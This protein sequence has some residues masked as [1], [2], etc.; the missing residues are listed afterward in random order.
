MNKDLEEI[1]TFYAT[2]P[3]DE[4]AKLLINKSKDNPIASL[5]DSL[6]SYINHKNSSTLR[7]FV[8]VSIAG[9]EHNPQK[10][11]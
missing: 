3:H 8:T 6:T 4:P 7:E 11:S 5:T 2:K 1:V 9:Y 10:L